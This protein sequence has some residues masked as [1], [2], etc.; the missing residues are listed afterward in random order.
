MYSY[1][2]TIFSWKDLFLSG[3]GLSFVDSVFNFIN[4]KLILFVL[5]CIVLIVMLFILSKYEKGYNLKSL[6]NAFIAI[7]CLVLLGSIY[8]YNL[9]KLSKIVDGWDASVA[10][11]NDANY[12]S[13]WKNTNKLILIGGTFDYIIRD[14]YE[15]FLKRENINKSYDYV[16]EYLQKSDKSLD[17]NAKYK[18]LF[19][20][21]NLILVMMES[22]DDWMISEE[23]TPTIWKMM[24]QGFNFTNHY[25][26]SYVTGKTANSEFIANTGIYPNV[27]NLS[28]NYAYNNNTYSYS[29]AN[30]F[31][32]SEYV[33]N[34]FHR[35]TGNVYN[36]VQ[37]HDALGYEKYFSYYDMG[38][39]DKNLDLDSYIAIDAYDKIVSNDKFMSFIITYSPHTPYEYSKVECQKNLKSIK[40]IKPK[41]SE[42]KICALSSARE[43]DN[44]FKILLKKLKK[45]KKL[46]DTIIIAFSDHPNNVI[47]KKNENDKLNKTVFFIYS[48]N[49]E[50][51]QIN[52]VSSTINILPTIKNLFDLK[53][54]YIYPACDLLNCKNNYVIFN[55]YTYYDGKKI[56]SLGEKQNTDLEYS[57]NLLI[58]DYYK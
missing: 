54:D 53:G 4:L 37:M 45:D 34:S 19:F 52:E 43:T 50:S 6:K 23:V 13:S 30:L 32:N 35:S 41:L 10:L 51:H 8:N 27:N 55:D 48:H 36:R 18:G 1:F 44:M 9:S 15:S 11:N 39:S 24:H 14:F 49:M 31:K 5:V 16:T 12:Y 17:N 58:S 29:L 2:G 38:I 47:L 20:N 21:K 28:P 7:V 26:P 46:D 40:K 33:V 22:M 57:K 56:L 25:S 42:E 3:E